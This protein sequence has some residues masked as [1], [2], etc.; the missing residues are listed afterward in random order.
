MRQFLLIVANLFLPLLLV[1]L[2]DAVWR[3]WLSRK[4][5]PEADVTARIPPLNLRRI[6]LAL[7]A[8]LAL[9]F[10]TLGILRLEVP[11]DISFHGN[12][13]RTGDLP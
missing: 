11:D 8:G 12:A 7:A 6:F 9:V 5:V 4:N 1:W 3:W 13:A 10:L 2:R